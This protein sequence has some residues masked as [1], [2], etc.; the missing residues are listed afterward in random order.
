MNEELEP[1]VETVEN[2]SVLESE[3]AQSMDDALWGGETDAV[4]E[5]VET[6]DTQEADAEQIKQAADTEEVAEESDAPPEGLSPK[7]SERFQKLANENR[8][9]KEFGSPEELTLMREDARTLGAFRERVMDCGM[10]P[11]EL[12]KVFMYTKA[13]KTGDWATAKR[14]LQEQ[15]YQFAVMSG[16][17]LVA[18]PLGAY[19]DLKQSVDGMTLD[20]EHAAEMARVRHMTEVNQRNQAQLAQNNQVHQQLAH[21][22][23][24]ALQQVDAMASGWAKSDLLWAEREPLMGQ[25]IE[26]ELVKLPAH[27]WAAG[28]QAFY[29]A[30]QA[31]PQQQRARTPNPLRSNNMGTAN[32]GAA[33]T[34]MADALWG[35]Q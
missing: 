13:V 29:S 14:F 19:P 26:N 10:Q 8:T 23:E 7:A 5:N 1:V 30:L 27:M 3:Q 20:K 28:L 21:E 2:E 6:T 22:R 33:P 31:Q 16:E 11:D 35:D 34:S 12:D 18:D 24:S 25:Y 17:E 32:A 15:A 9:Y 4:S